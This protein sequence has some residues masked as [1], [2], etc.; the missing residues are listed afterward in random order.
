M[1]FNYIKF[2]HYF[3]VFTFDNGKGVLELTEHEEGEYINTVFTRP[4]KDGSHRMILN[5]KPLNKFIEYKKFKMDTLKVV[6]S[7]VKPNCYMASID[8]RDAYYT[9]LIHPQHQKFLKFQWFNKLYKY[10]ALPNGY[11]AAP[12]IFTKIMKPIF[13]QLRRLGH[14][15]YWLYR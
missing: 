12:R 2:L 3:P 5:L 6:L 14:N 9:V 1:L 8:I 11:A 15:Y 7:L 4:K 13:A 10:T